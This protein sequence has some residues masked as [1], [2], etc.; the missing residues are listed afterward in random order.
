MKT[1]QY[2]SPSSIAKYKDNP[3]E[4]Y[5]NYLSDKAPPRFPQTEPMA[6]GSSFD[7]YVKSYLHQQL[8]GKSDHDST[9]KRSSRLK[10]NLKS[11]TR[12]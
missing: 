5:M 6:V 7:A 12:L 9:F 1:I 3:D 10:S 8:F 11:V 4:F 2:L